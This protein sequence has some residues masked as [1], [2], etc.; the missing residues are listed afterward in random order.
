M[1]LFACVVVGYCA[2]G[3]NIIFPIATLCYRIPLRLRATVVY[4]REVGASRERPIAYARDVVAYR[5]ARKAVAIIE[6]IIAYALDA[7]GDSKA[8]VGF[9]NCV[10]S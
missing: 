2:R 1:K 9:A 3:W 7:V 8:C 10:R 6:R 4:T 5:Y